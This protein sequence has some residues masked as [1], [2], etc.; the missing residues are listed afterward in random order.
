MFALLT[1]ETVST[2]NTIQPIDWSAT[3][4]WIALVVSIIGT[5]VG[6]IVTTILTNRHQL[7]LRKLDIADKEASEYFHNKRIA[8][9]NFL[10]YTA[11]YI[12]DGHRPTQNDCCEH[13]FLI[14]PYVSQESWEQLDKLYKYLDDGDLHSARNLFLTI[15]KELT[16]ILAKL[17]QP[18]DK[19]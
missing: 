19:Q 5:I 2:A 12:A 8:L 11:K 4:A 6:P 14:Y 15:S 10:S 1:A 18:K 17:P 7:M 16:A 9:E 3:A 13:F